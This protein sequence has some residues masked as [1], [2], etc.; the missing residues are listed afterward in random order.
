MRSRG[1]L[2]LGAVPLSSPPPTQRTA[3]NKSKRKKRGPYKKWSKDD[4]AVAPAAVRCAKNSPQHLSFERAEHQH[5]VPH[6]TLN[7][8]MQKTSA[9]IAAAPRGS[10]S[11]EITD[12]VIAT[13]RSGT[14][15]T[16]LNSDMEQ[17]LLT[18]VF[19]MEETCVPVDLDQLRLKAMRL[20]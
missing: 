16:L 11:N 20:H 13:T 7:R 19:K 2:S 5:H 14:P 8:Y 12:N 15:R 1:S 18:W 3:S 10:R 4:M 6:T 17:Q 9:A